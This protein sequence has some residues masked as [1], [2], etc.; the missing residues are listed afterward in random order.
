MYDD[1][2]M[3]R[4]NGS[5]GKKPAGGR[6]TRKSGGSRKERSDGRVLS[7]VGADGQ[8]IEVAVTGRVGHSV[9]PAKVSSGVELFGTKTGLA[10]YLGVAKTQPGRWIE[11][12]EVP[13]PVTA[14]LVTDLDYVWDRI[15]T[16]MGDQAAGIWVRSANAYLD[17]ASPLD[18]LKVHGPSQVIAALDAAEAGSYA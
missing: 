3:N 5:S 1:V 8:S 18:W 10:Q 9:A 11:G 13:T 12:A 4:G 17:G 16:D 7:V 14:R 15:T 6:L 2:M